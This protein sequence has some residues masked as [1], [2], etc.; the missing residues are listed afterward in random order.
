MLA[1]RVNSIQFH[2]SKL[3]LGPI[4]QN[5]TV[6][7]SSVRELRELGQFYTRS[8]PLPSVNLASGGQF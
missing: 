8:S 5:G 7:F 3:N 2:N 6:R 4:L 1:T